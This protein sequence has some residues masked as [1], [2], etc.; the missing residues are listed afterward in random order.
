MKNLTDSALEK[1][2]E[3]SQMMNYKPMKRWEYLYEIVFFLIL[4]KNI[5]FILLIKNKQG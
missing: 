5:Y 4:K 1:K 3:S 2:Y